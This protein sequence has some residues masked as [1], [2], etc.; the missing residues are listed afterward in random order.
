MTDHNERLAAQPTVAQVKAESV[1]EAVKAI[2][3]AWDGSWNLRGPEDP[4]TYYSVDVWLSR[5]ADRIESE[6]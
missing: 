6:G 2:R 1:R 5:Y 4:D 3:G